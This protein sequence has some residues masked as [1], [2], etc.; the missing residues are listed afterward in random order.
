MKL[1]RRGASLGG[2][3]S[4]PRGGAPRTDAR[5]LRRRVLVVSAAAAREGAGGHTRRHCRAHM[6][7]HL[8]SEMQPATWRGHASM[9]EPKPAHTPW[10]A[11]A[12]GAQSA[13]T[14]TAHEEPIGQA[15]W[16]GAR[17]GGDRHKRHGRISWNLSVNARQFT[18]AARR[19]ARF[20]R[21]ER[22]AALPHGHAAGNR[23]LLPDSAYRLRHVGKHSRR[24][25]HVMKDLAIDLV[26]PRQAC[27]V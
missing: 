23:C 13:A 11:H 8:A 16:T 26:K 12:R 21:C 7:A 24:H 15:N 20:T 3:V 17:P 10:G 2:S 6:C 1:V 18:P 27:L 14:S 9:N 5:A 4:A 25:G 22:R 19:H